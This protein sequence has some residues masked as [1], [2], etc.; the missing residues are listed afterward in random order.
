MGDRYTR[1]HL[2]RAARVLAEELGIPFATTDI[3]EGLHLERDGTGRGYRLTVTA[4]GSYSQPFASG[5]Y[6]RAGET[7]Y[8]MIHQTIDAVRFFK[9]LEV[10]RWNTVRFSKK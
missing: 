10:A 4:N 6:Y 7:A 9:K 5:R 2:I 3:E 8:W 1:E